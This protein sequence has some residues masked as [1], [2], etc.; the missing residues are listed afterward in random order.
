M[1]AV[2][3]YTRNPRTLET[4]RK[5][6]RSNSACTG[7][8]NKTQPINNN[9]GNKEKVKERE[10]LRKRALPDTVVSSPVVSANLEAK[11]EDH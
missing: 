7:L 10:R 9:K 1:W 3:A 2:V 11:T 6:A 8:Q 5:F 4:N